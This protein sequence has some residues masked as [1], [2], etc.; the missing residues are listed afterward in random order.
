MRI[1]SENLPGEKTLFALPQGLKLNYMTIS[2]HYDI[3]RKGKN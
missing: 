3:A 2:L 1:I